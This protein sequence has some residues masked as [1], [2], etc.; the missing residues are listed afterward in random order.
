MS[1]LLATLSA[2]KEVTVLRHVVLNLVLLRKLQ[3]YDMWSL[4]ISTVT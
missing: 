4:T 3:Y 1:L 2:V